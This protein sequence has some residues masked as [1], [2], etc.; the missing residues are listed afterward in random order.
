MEANS[1]RYPVE[2][3]FIPLWQ[4]RLATK[5]KAEKPSSPEG[6]SLPRPPAANHR[7]TEKLSEGN[8]L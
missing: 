2:A 5:E 7:E 1:E 3:V 4:Q 8:P 6:T